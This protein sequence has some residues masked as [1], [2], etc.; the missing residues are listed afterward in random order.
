LVVAAVLV[1]VAC[2]RSPSVSDGA[3]LPDFGGWWSWEP[4]PDDFGPQGPPQPLLHAPLKPEIVAAIR[5]V[6]SKVFDT[7]TSDRP[8]DADLGLDTSVYCQPPRF[9]GF[10][11]YYTVFFEILLTPGRATIADE[12]GLLRRVDMTG[13]PLPTDVPESRTGTS[14]GHWQGSTLV[15]ET[16]GFDSGAQFFGPFKFGKGM[17]TVERFSITAPDVMQIALQMTAPEIFDGVFER[18]YTFH[19]DRNHEFTDQNVCTRDDRSIDHSTGQQR[20]DMTPPEG[21][22]PPPSE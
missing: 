7:S 22:P 4:A 21:L 16:I 15:V 1:G 10:N 14:I 3:E 2:D 20:F 18:T 5:E 17:R 13:R 8:A 12:G 9:A 6:F 19:R 11:G